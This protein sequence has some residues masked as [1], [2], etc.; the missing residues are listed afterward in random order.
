MM[1]KK[2]LIGVSICAVILLVLGSFTNVVGYQSEKSTTMSESPLFSIRTQKATNKQQNIFTSQYL[3]KGKGT[4]LQFPARV[5]RTELFQK[6]IEFISDMNDETFEKFTELFVSRIKQDDTITDINLDEIKEILRQSRAKHEIVMNS[7]ISEPTYHA[8]V[9]C[10][11]LCNWFLG[12][13]PFWIVQFLAIIPAFIV[14]LIVY[15]FRVW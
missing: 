10:P 13:I 7:F 14:Y 15:F 12:C 3:G 4:L 9:L 8:T 1:N 5:N 11:T 6:A 2:P